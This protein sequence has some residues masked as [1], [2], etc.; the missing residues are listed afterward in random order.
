MAHQVPPEALAVAQEI[1]R[2]ARP[3]PRD[4]SRIAECCEALFVMGGNFAINAL[5]EEVPMVRAALPDP[6]AVDAGIR[7]A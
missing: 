2:L 6:L 7:G 4:V 3:R 5:R 1:A